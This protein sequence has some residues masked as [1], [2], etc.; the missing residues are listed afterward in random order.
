MAIQICMVA[1]LCSLRLSP[2]PSDGGLAERSLNHEAPGDAS[3]MR[4]PCARQ[5]PIAYR[6][7]ARAAITSQGGSS[8]EY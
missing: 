1:V 7:I 5:G 4:I 2:N 6:A 3:T 8:D